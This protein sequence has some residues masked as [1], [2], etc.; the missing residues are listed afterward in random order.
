MRHLGPVNGLCCNESSWHRRCRGCINCL[1]IL[2]GNRHHEVSVLFR[3]DMPDDERLSTAT[4]QLGPKC[5]KTGK[6]LKFSEAIVHDG[7]YLSY[8]AYLEL[9]GAEPSTEPKKVPGLR[10]E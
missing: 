10:M 2:H 6:P 4:G 3:E 5:A 7:E 1:G 9:T 8:E